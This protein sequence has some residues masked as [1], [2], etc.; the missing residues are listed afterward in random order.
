MSYA[1]IQSEGI[2]VRESDGEI[3]SP[4][5]SADD[6]DFQ[7]YLVWVASGGRPT[8]YFRLDLPSQEGEPGPVYQGAIDL[9]YITSKYVAST[10]ITVTRRQF[11][12]ALLQQGLLDTV[13]ALIASSGDRA[14]QLNYAEAIEFNRYN[15]LIL[16]MAESL[17]KSSA[18][19]DAFFSFAASIQ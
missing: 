18:E 2:V 11:K 14:L 5:Q 4:C 19:I 3:I 12:L 9:A 1:L 7:E 16:Q 13:E 17:E 15:P 10:P 6:P 8:E